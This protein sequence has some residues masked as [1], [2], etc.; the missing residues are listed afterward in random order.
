MVTKNKKKV[1]SK[2]GSH[3]WYTDRYSIAIYQ[4]NFLMLFLLATVFVMF[5]GVVYINLI[6]QKKTVDPFVV[7]IEQKSG[8]PTVVDQ[9]TKA[10]Y[11]S[12]EAVNNF[13]IY[14]YVRARENYDFRDYVYNYFT[15]VRVLSSGGVFKG[16][17]KQTNKRNADSPINMFGR[18]TTIKAKIK[19]VIDI[20]NK[21]DRAKSLATKQV[22]LLIQHIQQNRLVKEEHKVIIMKYRFV[23]LNLEF[24]ERLVNPLGFQVTFYKINDEFNIK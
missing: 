23:N 10:E 7:E 8:I 22:R 4:R 5:M 19:S 13:F 12:K 9:K 1:K 2:S 11:T 20:T 6:S 3:N 16:F 21:A 15:V 14:K 24:E 17:Y 18:K